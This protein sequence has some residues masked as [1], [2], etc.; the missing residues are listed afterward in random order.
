MSVP[1]RETPTAISYRGRFAPS[2]TGPLHFGSLV[3]AL[4]SYLEARH[5]QGQWLVRMEDLDPPREEPGAADAIL[6][7]LETYQL[8]WDGPVLYQSTRQAAYEAALTQLAKGH[9][10]FACG[11]SRKE[12][13]ASGATVY[14]GTCREGLP[15]GKQARAVRVRVPDQIQTFHDILQGSLRTDLL[16]EVGDFVVRRAD[17]LYAYHL[18][19]VVDDAAQ[20]ISHIVRGSDLLDATPPQ[21]Y[22]QQCLGYSHPEYCHLPVAVNQQGQKLSK[23][24]FAAPLDERNP[25]HT[26]VRALTFLG[27]PPPD[28][29]RGA[30][31]GLLLR[32]AEAQWDLEKVPHC[33]AICSEPDDN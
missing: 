8:H 7:A 15:P 4:G 13:A 10:S 29:L 28:E 32:W 19:V 21:R 11:C 31:P 6:R 17:G 16:R 3:T 27:H 18:A 33:A 22:L 5:Q 20:G 25:G 12:I 14:P 1:I 23:Q 26:L 2:P 24:T 30:D 9:Y